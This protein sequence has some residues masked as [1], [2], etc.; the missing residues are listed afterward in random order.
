MKT[1][2]I[3]FDLE[4]CALCPTTAVMSMGAVAWQR[5]ATETP[6]LL[7]E[8]K[9]KTVTF[10]PSYV[11]SAHV[12]LRGMFVDGFTFD[13]QTADWW[14]KRSDDAKRA[15]LATDCEDRPCAPI[16]KV[17]K[18][19]FEWLLYVK[20]TT[21]ADEVCLWSQGSDF[22]IAI[23][24]NICS[25]YHIDLPVSYKNFRDHRTFYME[26]ARIIC[27]IA[28]VEFDA[29]RAYSLVDEYDEK[30]AAHDPVYDCK[31]S[32]FSTWQMMKHMRCLRRPGNKPTKK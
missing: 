8:N 24:R 11:F 18:D 16:E 28:G 21:E 10:D 15:V 27:A 30:G 6:F 32:I 4:T 26:G 3:T 1:I 12:D 14:A 23:L 19:F 5:Q 29:D 7:I 13:Q 17:V 22:D 20:M 31:R 9:T 25:R 2:D